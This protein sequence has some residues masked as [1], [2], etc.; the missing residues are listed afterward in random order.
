MF[1]F[2]RSLI[3]LVFISVLVGSI[4]ILIPFVSRGQG[5]TPFGPRRFYLTR[6]QAYKG[7]Q[8]LTACASGFHMASM[9]E[10][11]D[12]SNLKYD[13]T[14]GATTA[15]S[16]FGPPTLVAVSAEL[17]FNRGWVRTGARS[18]SLSAGDPGTR[19]CDA[20]TSDGA[21]AVGTVAWLPVDWA[22]TVLHPTAPF[23]AEVAR[24]NTPQQVWCVQD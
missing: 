21:T 6:E 9:W 4:A 7:N 22:T 15:D 17:I 14:L 19:N 24:C 16:G 8:A 2:K 18:A 23:D 5:N 1:S 20:Y 3:A 11:V 12:P 13:T 10:I